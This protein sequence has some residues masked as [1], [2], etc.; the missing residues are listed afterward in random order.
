MGHQKSIS[1]GLEAAV[2]QSPIT[3]GLLFANTQD[4]E[5]FMTN[6]SHISSW[7]EGKLYAEAVVHVQHPELYDIQS[8]ASSAAKKFAVEFS[9]SKSKKVIFNGKS[10]KQVTLC[11]QAVQS[12]LCPLKIHLGERKQQIHV[13]ECSCTMCGALRLNYQRTHST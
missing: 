9:I 3:L 2:M 13:H 6:N 11:A 10:P 4:A 1:V 12:Y 7:P 8:L 5:Q